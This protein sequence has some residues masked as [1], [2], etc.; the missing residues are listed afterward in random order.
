MASLKNKSLPFLLSIGLLCSCASHPGRLQADL[1]LSGATV[2]TGVP[3]QAAQEA[4]AIRGER[5]V[6]VGRDE[7]IRR[8]Q[9]PGSTVLELDGRFVMPGFIDNHAHFISGGFQMLGIDLRPATDE[10]DFADRVR[11]YA[12]TVPRGTWILNGDWDHEAWPSQAIPHRKLVDEFTTGHPVFVNRLDGHMALANSLALKLAGITRHTPDPPGGAIVRDESGEPT[13]MLKDAAMGLVERVIPQASPEDRI[14]AAREAFKEARRL[15][16]TSVND[17]ASFE[18][19]RTYQQL[20]DQDDV[21]ARIYAI[22]PLPDWN[23]LQQAGIEKNFGGDYL[24]IGA[25]KGY[26]DG[27]LGSTTAWFY[28]PYL[29]DP[30]T[31]GLPAGMWFPEGNM[32]KLVFEADAAGLHLAIHAIGDR[33]NDELLRIYADLES[34][35]GRKDRRMRIE[36]AQ[37]LSPAGIQAF[38]KQ[39]VIASMQPYHAI[40]DGRWAE[41]RIGPERIKTTYAFRS[42]LDDGAL[43]TFGS[44]WSVAPLNPLLGVYAAVTRRTLDGKNP[45]GWVP[46]E[47]ITVEEA[48]VS[49]TRNNAFAMFREQDLGTL[50]AGKLADLVV[51]STN[52]MLVD[53]AEIGN[54]EVQ[55]TIVGGKTVFEK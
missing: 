51:L 39:R 17:M 37:H 40:D 36:H 49:Y 38:G 9:G 53:P 52:P 11:D 20:L 54:I 31:R 14:R 7:E 25:V 15:G 6:A 46:E 32:R 48:L 34:E 12:S 41:K 21:T 22:T 16:V 4:I 50:E 33:A 23:R 45:G 43:L 3:G 1:I 44:D 24:R 27:S 2:W 28:E 35:R 42:L 18:D 10:Q 47:K 26:V 8:Y 30:G 5:I 19:V 55:R 29:D 13:G